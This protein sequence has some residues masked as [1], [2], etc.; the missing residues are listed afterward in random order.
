MM[1]EEYIKE[2]DL[3][4]MKGLQRILQF[5]YLNFNNDT[6]LINEILP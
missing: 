6:I 3:K 5:L 4:S 1:S 2:H